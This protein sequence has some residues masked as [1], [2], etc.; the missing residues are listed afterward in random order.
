MNSELLEF[1]I[2]ELNMVEL[3]FLFSKL[4]R[5]VVSRL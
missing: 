5:I 4:E 2:L 1:F 3:E